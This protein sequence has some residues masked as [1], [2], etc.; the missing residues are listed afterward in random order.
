MKDLE[1]FIGNLI[2]SQGVAFISSIDQDGFPNTKAMLAPRKREGMRAF[3][4]TTK[5]S[6]MR[7]GQ[8]KARPKASV[9]V[10]DDK[11]FKG[12][13]F[14]GFMEVLE[15]SKYKEMIWQD[16]D[17]RFYPGGITDP[18]YS[19]LRFTAK[20]GRIYS[21]AGCENFVVE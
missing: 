13:M 4:F 6:S 11:S 5:T 3:Y 16:G 15:D 14:T 12:V 2:D 18:D 9:Y 1:A 17:T 8:Y 21:K 19:V 10:C 7:V 20:Q